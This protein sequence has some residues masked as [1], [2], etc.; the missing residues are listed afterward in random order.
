MTVVV[1]LAG[2]TPPARYD[3]IPWTEASIEESANG[4]TGWAVIDTVTLDPVDTDPANPDERSFT[5]TL[6]TSANLYY[7]VRFADDDG[8][9]SGYTTVVQYT[10]GAVAPYATVAELARL[11]KVDATTYNTQLTEALTAAA[12]EIAS[13][14]GRGADDPLVEDWEQALAAQVNLERAAEHW[15]Q[16]QV[17]FGLIGLD[18]DLPVRLARDTWE[19]HAH[20]LAPLKRQWGIA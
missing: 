10:D 13:E 9:H 16:R 6:G 12:G 8:N 17:T 14:I 15:K 5:T 19:R 3:D 4:T 11:M 2:L 20:K 1:S 7:R 18:T